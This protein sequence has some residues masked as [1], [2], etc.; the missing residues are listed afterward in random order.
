MLPPI[1]AS[2]SSVG[3]SSKSGD[4]SEIVELQDAHLRG[5]DGRDR[6]RRDRDVGAA[7]DVRLDQLEE[8]HAVEMVAGQDQEVVGVEALEV[9]RRLADRICRALEPCRAVRGLF[10]GQHFDEA[11]RE[12]VE[13]VGLRDVA[14]QGRGVELGQHEDALEAGVQAVADRDVDEPV[15]AGERHRRLGAHVRERK[16]ARAAAAAQNQGQHVIH[17]DIIL[18]RARFAIIGRVSGRVL[19][20]TR[21]TMPSPERYRCMGT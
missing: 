1:S 16:E 15:L 20:C 11:V 7:F 10:G 5:I 6:L 18:S 4:L 14:V 2:R 17:D 8:I 13:A 21:D 9:A 3:F 12:R 19:S